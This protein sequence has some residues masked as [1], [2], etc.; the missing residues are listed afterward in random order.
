M[1]GS[2]SVQRVFD[3]QVVSYKVYENINTQRQFEDLYE[4]VC[5]KFETDDYV[6]LDRCR[7]A[8]RRKFWRIGGS[9]PIA[10]V[11]DSWRITYTTKSRMEIVE[12][13]RSLGLTPPSSFK[14]IYELEV[15]WSHDDDLP[16]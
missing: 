6:V 9:A 13:Y 10:Q 7:L 11:L 3:S 16:F 5:S 8:R 4:R 2:V 15:Q 1:N 12:S 14:Y